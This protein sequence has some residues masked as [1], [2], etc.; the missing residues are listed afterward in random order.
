MFKKI[1]LLC[2]V[3]LSS[4]QV[5]AKQ[6]RL[7]VDWATFRY[8][9]KQLYV[10]IYYSF[11]ESELNYKEADNHF[12]ALTWGRLKVFRNDTLYKDFY[13][14]NQNQ[15]HDLQELTVPKSITDQVGFLFDPGDYSCRLILADL[16]DSENADSVGW[17]LS[18][19]RPG[20]NV[21]C[22]DI[23]LAS[24][25]QP[26][27]QKA[28]SPFYKNTLI[29][30]PNPSLL[31]DKNTPMLFFYTEVY[32]LPKAIDEESYVL[33]YYIVDSNDAIVKDIKPKTTT[34]KQIVHPSVE[35]G[36]L[37][38]GRL[39][40]GT[41]KLHM[42]L[43]K[44]SG[45]LLANKEKKFFIYQPGETLASN[46]SQNAASDFMMTIFQNKDST[47]VENEFEMVYY[48]LDRNGQKIWSSVHSLSGRR[49]FLYYFWRRRDPNTSTP[50]N[51]FRNEYLKRYSVAN[52]KFRAFKLAGWK[53]DRG[54]VYMVY[55][56]PSD[57]ERH[58]NEPNLYP[59]EIWYYNQLQNG[60]L[61]V[62]ADL[63][64]NNNYRLLHSTL[65]G[66]IQDY[67]YT[68]ILRKGYK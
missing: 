35:I 61:F 42:E 2:F 17:K 13:W 8:D 39:S 46:Q 19:K 10:E 65:V 7:S 36:M 41:Y 38:V 63:E 47:Q 22:S 15:I 53:T 23:E 18:L 4:V 49:Q 3:L 44:P 29:V 45:E 57:V 37:N 33:K 43:L 26:S 62:F 34:K 20:N 5:F 21:Y 48:L 59:Y 56:P 52:R 27:P 30:Q 64:G 24:S 68:D 25:I 40:T 14:K 16:N 28:N 11:I 55:G 32:N 58:P 60:V 1:F 51:E 6:I 12:L 9:A 31:Y 50:Q 67:N 54:R 66:E